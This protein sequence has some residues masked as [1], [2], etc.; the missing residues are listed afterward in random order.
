MLTSLKNEIFEMIWIW[1]KTW[2]IMGDETRLFF[3]SWINFRNYLFLNSNN[4][5]IFLSEHLKY[6][7]LNIVFLCFRLQVLAKVM[8]AKYLHR[9]IRYE[10]SKQKEWKYFSTD[11][12]DPIVSQT[13]IIATHR[14][15]SNKNKKQKYISI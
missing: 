7:I 9:E 12:L 14:T 8:S 13:W 5:F 15:L 3:R 2:N 1:I 10:I 6:V 4:I 11:I